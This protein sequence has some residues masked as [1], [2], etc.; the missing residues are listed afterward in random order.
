MY[1]PPRKK[2]TSR[3]ER[4]PHRR[5]TRL[6]TPAESAYAEKIT[7]LCYTNPFSEA[8]LALEKQALGSSYQRANDAWHLGPG[9]RNKNLRP[10]TQRTRELLEKVRHD[11]HRGTPNEV[12]LYAGLLRFWIYYE[13]NDALL[14][15]A[16]RSFQPGFSSHRVELFRQ[17]R[18]D[19][20]HYASASVLRSAL[21]QPPHLFALL[22]QLRRAFE[23]IFSSIIGS[24]LPARQ[25]REHLWQSV[26]S[27]DMRRYE[28][29]L[30]RRM[31][32]FPTLVLGPSGTGKELVAR[33][34]G[35]SRYLP[36]DERRECFVEEVTDG[37]RPLNVSSLAPGLMES[38]LFGHAR[39]AFTNAVRDRAG[40][41]ES[42][43]AHGTVFLDE[44]GEMESSV[45]VK[46]LRVL[47]TR[48][49]HRV[50]DT[51]PRQFLGKFVSATN[52]D[53]QQEIEAGRFRADFYYRLCADVVRTPSLAEQ[54]A[55][56]PGDLQLLVAH[57]ASRLV[58]GD[59]VGAVVSEVCGVV[60]RRLGADY[61]WPG[62]IRELEQCV[63]NVLIRGDYVPGSASTPREPNSAALARA[64]L[65]GSFN[66][67]QLL[68]VYVT[69]EYQRLKS[70]SETGRKLG[71][72]RR[73]VKARVDP[74]LLAKPR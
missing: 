21:P 54:L 14:S 29:V 9:H 39:G 74:S 43:P 72:D 31:H 3:R 12:G 46:L 47:Q 22:F 42:C 56:T 53:L 70:Y 17:F 45:Q 2:V 34:I 8:R 58:Q 71:L 18:Q 27:N 35:M 20:N 49:F 10:L 30:F 6:L 50:G 7:A 55:D 59:E 13:H 26:F 36:F 11:I 60:E 28:R 41:L 24:S 37:F 62:N 1:M 51:L 38:E 25:L 19:F 73:T 23:Q 48:Q 66:V 16:Q 57:V 67:E 61:A 69:L 5:G 64:F 4:G 68:D 63:R 52:R 65:D 44:I 33:G 40:W 15:L 32:E